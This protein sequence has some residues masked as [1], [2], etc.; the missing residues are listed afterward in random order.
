MASP[1]LAFLGCAYVH[2]PCACA[3][4]HW[5]QGGCLWLHA[6]DRRIRHF[7]AYNQG[8]IHAH[9]GMGPLQIR[10]RMPVLIM[11]LNGTL[12][13]G[14]T[15]MLAGQR[16]SIT[17]QRGPGPGT[18]T[19]IERRT[20]ELGVTIRSQVVLFTLYSL[21]VTARGCIQ[22]NVSYEKI[23]VHHIRI[24]HRGGRVQPQAPMINMSTG[25]G[26]ST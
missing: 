18:R 4:G 6:D 10:R 13:P 21:E 11:P 23:V 26:S 16:G 14:R 24:R 8:N 3:Q 2:S 5:G 7:P 20:Q 15:T 12:A 25:A 22:S 19:L 17:A 9:F 1:G